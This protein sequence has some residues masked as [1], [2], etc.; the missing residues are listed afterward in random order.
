[1]S[2]AMYFGG[3]CLLLPW[4]AVW[5][6]DWKVLSLVMAAPMLVTVLVP[7]IVPES[8]RLVYVNKKDI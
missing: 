3:G 6:S 5:I 7:F 8:A 2:I 1:M 4:F